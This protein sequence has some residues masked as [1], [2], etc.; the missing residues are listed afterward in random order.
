M[1]IFLVLKLVDFQELFYIPLMLQ[2]T[3]T[4]QSKGTAVST[5]DTSQ[6]DEDLQQESEEVDTKQHTVETSFPIESPK[7]TEQQRK[8]IEEEKEVERALEALEEDELTLQPDTGNYFLTSGQFS[9]P[10]KLSRNIL[11][12]NATVRNNGGR[13]TIGI[14]AEITE[15]TIVLK[16]LFETLK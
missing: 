4:D 2:F 14:Q 1:I 11:I 16:C 13:M 3:P 10:K 6:Q 12:N 7:I 15:E 5:E 9:L 8:Q